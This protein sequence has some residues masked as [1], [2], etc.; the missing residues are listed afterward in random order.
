MNTRKGPT[1]TWKGGQDTR[2][3]SAVRQAAKVEP[4]HGRI[5]AR[6]GAAQQEIEQEGSN[7]IVTPQRPTAITIARKSS[8]IQQ[9][10]IANGSEGIQGRDESHLM[11]IA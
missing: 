1:C 6:R 4:Q 2:D 9:R 3:E 11:A 8:E 10:H 5:A 7:K